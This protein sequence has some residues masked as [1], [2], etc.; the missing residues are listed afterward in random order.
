[1]VCLITLVEREKEREERGE[2][3]QGQFGFDKQQGLVLNP[4]NISKTKTMKIS[5]I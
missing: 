1:L 3:A 5:I 2:R 4:F